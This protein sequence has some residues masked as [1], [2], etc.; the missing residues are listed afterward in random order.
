MPTLIVL[1]TALGVA[2]LWIWRVRSASHA[3]QEIVEAADDVRALLRRVGFEA[4]AGRH[5]ADAIDDPRLA[6]A[7]MM[8]AMA[9]LDGDLTKDQTDALRVECRAAFRV[10]QREADDFAAFG[11]W[12][13]SQAQKPDDILRRLTTVLKRIA[14]RE[15]HED[16]VNML[17][18]VASI[19]GGGPSELQKAA[20]QRVR[21][22]LDV[23]LH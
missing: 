8:A 21:R 16:M 10:T 11:R 22:S 19:E 9:R 4:K 1:V 14:P 7:G 12:L 23:A 15:A 5:P 6:A 13:A 2:A 18:R 3:A 17:T 20:I